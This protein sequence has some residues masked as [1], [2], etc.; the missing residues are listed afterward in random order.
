MFILP[1]PTTVHTLHLTNPNVSVSISE[2]IDALVDTVRRFST[3]EGLD[4]TSEFAGGQTIIH[5]TKTNNHTNDFMDVRAD[6][7]MASFEFDQNGNLR[8]R[9]TW[10]TPRAELNAEQ[11]FRVASVIRR[12]CAGPGLD[13]CLQP[14]VRVTIQPRARTYAVTVQS[15]AGDQPRKALYVSRQNGITLARR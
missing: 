8:D 7:L 14:S 11:M 6:D 3:E 4:L 10:M 12:V 15:L 9:A 1:S 13:S 5:I 2:S